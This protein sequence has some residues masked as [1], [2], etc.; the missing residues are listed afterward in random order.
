MSWRRTKHPGVFVRHRKGCPSA[1]QEGARCRCQPSYRARR[2]HP[3]TGKPQWSRTYR[4]RAEAL[5]WL[6]V[7]EKAAPAVRERAAAG[8]TFGELAD[9]WWAGVQAGKAG[10]FGPILALPSKFAATWP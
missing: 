2:R 6:S 7:G 1:V 4:E 3:T 10:G 8:P 5:T 9:E